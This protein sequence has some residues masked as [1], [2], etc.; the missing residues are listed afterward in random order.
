MSEK[1]KD[2]LEFLLYVFV[3]G[4]FIG[5]CVCVYLYTRTFSGALSSESNNWSNLGGFF[6]GVFSP[7]I[8]FVTLVAIVITIRL[9]RTMLQMQSDEFIRIYEVQDKV[10]KSQESQFSHALASSESDKVASYKQI[11]LSVIA[12]QIGLYQTIIDRSIQSSNYLLEKKIQH[13]KLDIDTDIENALKRKEE[14]ENIL[15]KLSGLSLTIAVTNYRAVSDLD[16]EFSNAY[17]EI[18]DLH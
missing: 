3:G 6:G 17:L 14:S 9:Q 16:R 8:S 7:V 1:R 13:S 11:I 12:Q 5:F 15:S 2:P 10:L 18:L 4:V